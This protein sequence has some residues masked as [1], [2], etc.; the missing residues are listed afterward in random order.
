MK[1]RPYQTAAVDRARAAYTAGKRRLLFV[2]PTGAGKTVIATE[3]LIRPSLS[4]G[5][6]VLFI[7]HRMELI[8]QCAAKLT[9][10]R[11]GIIKAGCPAD[12]YATV[13]VASVQTLA[14]RSA[15][16]PADLVVVD[17]A[18][19][20]TDEN[21]YGRILATYA[22]AC[23]AGLTATPYRLDGRGLGSVFDAIIPVASVA[24]LIRL[25]ALVRPR[26]FAL[27]APDL[28]GVRTVA[29]DYSESGLANAM[30]TKRIG[31]ALVETYQRHAAGRSAIAFA[32]NVLHA[33][34]IAQQFNAAG[35]PSACVHGGTP[36]DERADILARLASG[37]LLLVSNC[38]VLTEG[39]DCPRVSCVI[40]ARPTKSRGLWR[41]MVGRGLRPDLPTG[42]MDCQVHDHAGCRSTHGDITDDEDVD[43]ADGVSVRAKVGMG[44][45]TCMQCYAIMPSTA[46]VCDECN[47]PFPAPPPPELPEGEH[48]VLEEA[49]PAPKA[50]PEERQRMLRAIVAEAAIRGW[51]PGAVSH[52]YKALYGEWPSR[53]GEIT[54]MVDDERTRLAS[55]MPPAGAKLADFDALYE[56]LR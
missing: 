2:A 40:L 11:V 42:K 5:L 17:E 13:Q 22:T 7:A 10:L 6:R 35:I 33:E 48:V 1:L 39:F 4:R 32:T 56:A 54:R 3:G 30:D 27:P 28:R 55:V 24:E 41:Q 25:E 50:S 23:F 44:T 45:K 16:P 14:R 47:A 18:H 19:H 49:A 21:S 29:G 9:G 8:E 34:H 36:A 51:K 31:T 26:T 37:A 38:G 53:I 43:L 20:V 15:M 52:K 46:Q 12:P